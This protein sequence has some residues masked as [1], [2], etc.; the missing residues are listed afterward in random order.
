MRDNQNRLDFDKKFVQESWNS[1][2]IQLDKELP[3]KKSHARKWIGGL[4][5]LQ[6]I[7]LMVIGYLFVENSGLTD[8][9]FTKLT[10]SEVIEN[11]IIK[12]VIEKVEIPQKPTI[13]Y[14][15]KTLPQQTEPAIKNNP[16]VG[17]TDN[18]GDR[19]N[20]NQLITPREIGTLMSLP[21][22]R[23]I[24]N[25]V[26][27]NAQENLLDDKLGI[28]FPAEKRPFINLKKFDF[29]V[30][31]SS[32]VSN[33]LDYTGYGFLSSLT[34]NISEKFKV[35]TG[36]GFNQISRQFL[37]V[38]FLEK[39]TTYQNKSINYPDAFYDNLE[40]L[41]QIYIPFN[42]SYVINETFDLTAGIN[43]RHTFD[44]QLSYRFENKLKEKYMG[45]NEPLDL[46]LNE[47]NVGITVGFNYKLSNRWSLMMN[48]E[49]GLSSIIS[50]DQFDS[51]K[52]NYDLNLMNLTTL[53]SF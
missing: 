35:S 7:S 37:F 2:K 46:Y 48:T 13:V 41:K 44:S 8:R 6:C 50:K 53:Y 28:A 34:V 18:K 49:W 27:N 1:L 15:Y 42:V 20:L 47:T 36:I 39:S 52:P 3:V 45:I 26:A 16:L 40:D 14:R 21:T 5:A 24:E 12:T 23:N 10:K 29:G 43:F 51:R 22:A 9:P 33:D 4:L 17:I 31:F 30:G 25:V 19:S 32:V 38:P 11:T